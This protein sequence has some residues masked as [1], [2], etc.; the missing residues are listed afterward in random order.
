MTNNTITVSIDL[1]H[2]LKIIYAE[3]A[4]RYATQRSEGKGAAGFLAGMGLN[5][6]SLPFLSSYFPGV[7][8]KY[9]K[10]LG[11]LSEVSPLAGG[12][13]LSDTFG[14]YSIILIAQC[15]FNHRHILC[16]YKLAALRHHI[17]RN[18]FGKIEVCLVQNCVVFRT[19]ICLNQI[20]KV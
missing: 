20:W 11:E 9:S 3:S 6:L 13:T 19:F 4:W 5:F 10:A 8:K 14:L 15:E 18:V 2:L 1:A 7:S 17:R 12:I 16:A